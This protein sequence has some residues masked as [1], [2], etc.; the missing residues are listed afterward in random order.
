MKILIVTLL[1]SASLLSTACTNSFAFYNTDSD[2]ASAYKKQYRDHFNKPE[3]KYLTAVHKKANRKPRKAVEPYDAKIEKRA[4]KFTVDQLHE[5]NHVSFSLSQRLCN[6]QIYVRPFSN[7]RSSCSG[8]GYFSSCN[9][10]TTDGGGYTYTRKFA[11]EM[12]D[13]EQKILDKDHEN[14]IYLPD[15]K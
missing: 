7:S 10:R 2:G 6:T 13:E 3:L 14:G 11:C 1:L 5:I 12:A 8:R 4:S 15:E 9:Y